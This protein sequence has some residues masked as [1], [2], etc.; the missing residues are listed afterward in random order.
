M[1][2]ADIPCSCCPPWHDESPTQDGMSYQH[3]THSCVATGA[4]QALLLPNRQLSG[5]QV[6]KGKAK[7][8]NKLAAHVPGNS[9]Q[10]GTTGAE[11]PNTPLTNLNTRPQHRQRACTNTSVSAH[12]NTARLPTQ[13]H[14]HTQL[15]RPVVHA[16][17]LH[18]PTKKC[19]T[20]KGKRIPGAFAQQAQASYSRR[21]QHCPTLT[22]LQHPARG[23]TQHVLQQTAQAPH[24]RTQHT[25]NRGPNVHPAA[26]RRSA[27]S[28]KTP[29]EQQ[30]SQPEQH[31]DLRHSVT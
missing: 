9:L 19:S 15:R 18:T 7:E 21:P 25:H 10:E 12:T 4:T 5:W 28:P 31:V 24:H 13:T 14:K 22:K 1:L 2:V 11:C 6:R 30:P 26:C 16:G 3:S 27:H 23:Y 17:A 29:C 8:C 20:C